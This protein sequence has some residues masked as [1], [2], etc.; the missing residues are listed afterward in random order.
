MLD[1]T[2]PGFP[3]CLVTNQEMQVPE[4]VPQIAVLDGGLVGDTQMVATCN[5]LEQCEMRR[6]R[7]VES[8]HERID[9]PY[10]AL[11][12]DDDVGPPFAGADGAVG[13]CDGFESADDRRAHRDNSPTIRPGAIHCRR[14]TPRDTESL[15]VRRLSSLEARHARVQDDRRDHDALRLEAHDDIRRERPT[16]RRHLGAARPIPNIV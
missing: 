7:L 16:R 3:L 9:G 11:G 5:R 10:A 2:R 6:A 14:R 15:R 13:R 8:S 1:A 4:L 12:S